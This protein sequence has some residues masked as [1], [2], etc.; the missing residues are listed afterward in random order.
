MLTVPS[1]GFLIAEKLVAKQI[2]IMSSLAAFQERILYS[3]GGLGSHSLNFFIGWKIFF[4]KKSMTANLTKTIEWRKFHLFSL[5]NFVL[6]YLIESP[7][8]WNEWVWGPYHPSIHGMAWHGIEY[9]VLL[10]KVFLRSKEL[11]LIF[12]GVISLSTFSLLLCNRWSWRGGTESDGI[13]YDEGFTNK[14]IY[15]LNVI[16]R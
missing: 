12:V 7:D 5:G 16:R 9:R 1:I 3:S 10:K 2:I 6:F 14:N 11:L 8:S 4:W 13:D 15:K